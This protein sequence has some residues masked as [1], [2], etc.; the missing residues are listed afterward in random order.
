M[1]INFA[2]G[3][4]MLTP[5]EY[6][7]LS[8]EE[9]GNFKEM[10]FDEHMGPGDDIEVCY[11][12]GKAGLCGK[13]VPFWVQHHRLTEHGDVDQSETIKKMGAYFKKKHG[14]K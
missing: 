3:K 11:R 1:M 13:V 2:N 14:I 6:S 12:L 10:V 4:E 9:K 5:K 7:K 8:L